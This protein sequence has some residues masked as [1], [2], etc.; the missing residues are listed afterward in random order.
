MRVPKAGCGCVRIALLI[1][2]V[3]S[4]RVEGRPTS[5][6]ATMA[7]ILMD[8][9]HVCSP[10]QRRTLEVVLRQGVGTESE[11]TLARAIVRIV[12]MP[13]PDDVAELKRLANDESV[14]D[15]VRTIARVGPIRP[16]CGTR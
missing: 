15:D 11:R 9:E 2:V 10:V 1:G 8:L 6:V 14:P 13:H 16:C 7:A 3:G 4:A 12:H 5:P